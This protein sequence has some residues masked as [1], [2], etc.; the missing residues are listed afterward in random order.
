MSTRCLT[1]FAFCDADFERRLQ[2][3]AL[4]VKRSELGIGRGDAGR[5]RQPRLVEFVARGSGLGLGGARGGAILAPQV[6]VE[7][8][9]DAGGAAVVP[10][11]GDAGRG[12]SVSCSAWTVPALAKASTCGFSA[13]PARW[14]KPSAARSRAEAAARSGASAKRLLHQLGKLRIAIAPPPALG[15]P[16][17]ARRGKRLVGD[18]V[19]RRA[20]LR[21]RP[22]DRESTHK[23]WSAA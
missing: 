6:E 2:A 19:A 5:D 9:G 14:A 4:G 3:V 13:A 11:V 17:G 23:R 1:S 21:L 15:R 7:R 8:E 16:F 12:R 20:R 22:R 18:E 10:A